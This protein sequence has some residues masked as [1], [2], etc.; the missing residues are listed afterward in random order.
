MGNKIF[1]M[2]A[3]AIGIIAVFWFAAPWIYRILFPAYT[4]A[5]P[6]SRL[7]SFNLL[8][9]GFVPLGSYFTSHKKIKEQYIANVGGNAIIIVFMFI[10]VIFWGLWGLIAAR[11]AASI[12]TAILSLI[13]YLY[14]TTADRRHAV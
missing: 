6:Y 7:Y 9:L 4:A 3:F 13:L 8:G 1:W 11:V 12:V 10:G 2:S 14:A 5:I